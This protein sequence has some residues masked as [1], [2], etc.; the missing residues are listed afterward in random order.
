VDTDQFNLA[1]T[2]GGLILGNTATTTGTAN[3]VQ[4]ETAGPVLARA[5]TTYTFAE[6]A[7][8][9]TVLANYTTSWQCVHRGVSNT[10]SASGTG[11][12]FSLTPTSGQ[13]IVC[14][15]TNSAPRLKLT[16]ASTATQV[17]PGGQVPY[18][19]TV[20]NTGAVAATNVVVTDTLPV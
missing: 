12:T 3:G 4:S 17:V 19:I 18:T 20:A 6:T 13:A 8:G 10:T 14:T 7:A 2:G 9:S 5:G 11:N 15:F 1:I 16:K